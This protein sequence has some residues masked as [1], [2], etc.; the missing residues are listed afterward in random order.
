MLL[1]PTRIS[2]TSKE[3]FTRRVAEHRAAGAPLVDGYAPFCRH[4]FVP[5]F[6]GARVPV[7]RITEHNRGLLA[8]GYKRRKQGELAVLSRWFPAEAVETPE[9]R[10][11]D[12]ILYSREQVVQERAAQEGLSPEEAEAAVPQAPWGIISV[13]AQ[14]EDFETPMQPITMMRNALG[15]EEGGSGVPL[16][17]DKY[18][19]S[20]AYW[21]DHAPVA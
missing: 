6:V 14:D 13:K 19:A 3:D 7:L 12:V 1:W 2:G 10:M 20:V 8:S 11:L 17:R 9:A 16:D 21:E 5:D 4:V 18:E 15:K